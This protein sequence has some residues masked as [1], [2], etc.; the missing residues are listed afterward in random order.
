MGKMRQLTTNE[1]YMKKILFTFLLLLSA[2]E[3]RV[4]D[5]VAI[6]VK[7][8]PI[9]LYEVKAMMNEAK[10]DEDK[11]VQILIRKKLEDL[12]I[13]TR[14]LQV[15]RKEVYADIEQMAEQNKMSMLE[16]YNAVQESNHLSEA[17]F[18]IK[19]KEKLLNQKLYSSIAYSSMAEPS[20]DEMNEYYEM[21]KNEFTHPERYEVVVYMTGDKARLQ[22]KI[23][24]PMFYSPEIKSDNASIEH[25]KVNPQL[26]TVLQNTKQG[27]F[28][29]IIPNPQGGFMSFYMK[30]KIGESAQSFDAL[31]A[32]IKNII[33]GAQRANVLDDYFARARLKADIQMLRLPSGKDF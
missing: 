31:K 19:I 3:A 25:A 26:A 16:L 6:L 18:K 27:A 9:S 24:N 10:V 11:A 12:E 28:T 21:H 22:E 4:V 17:Q 2:L 7:D 20:S 23:D 5:G 33:M 14:N 13:E 15:T 30:E 29:Q 32:Q 1:I 8:S